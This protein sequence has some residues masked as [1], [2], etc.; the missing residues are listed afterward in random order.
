MKKRKRVYIYIR[1]ST[2]EQAEEGYSL[3][4]QEKNLIDY[5]KA[6]GWEIVYVFIDGGQS[7]ASLERPE[8][9]NMIKGIKQ[10]KADIVL[11]DKLDRLSRSQFDT[12]FLINKV[13]EPNNVSLVSRTEAFDTSTQ[14]GKAMV[15]FMSIFAELERGRIK[16]RTS[17]GR[18]ARA[19]E[20][21]YRGGGKPVIGY[22]YNKI[23]GLL[24]INEYEAMQLREV[25]QL[26]NQRTPVYQI[27][28]R[29]YEKGYRTKHGE[30]QELT[31]RKCVANPLYVGKIKYKGNIYD[32]IHDAIVDQATYK[33]ALQILA[34][35]DMQYEKYKQGRTYHA[36]LGG[37][38][39]CANCGAR[40]HYRTRQGKTT[41][42]YYMCYSR[43]KCDKKMVRDHNCKNTNYRAE[44]LEDAVY[45]EVRKLK[46][47]IGYFENVQSTENESIKIDMIE[48]RIE[49]IKKQIANLNMLFSLDNMDFES[50]QEQIN[51]LN[52][53]R[54]QLMTELELIK[55]GEKRK[56]K[57]E[58]TTLVDIFEKA[59]AEED[60]TRINHI[61][62]ELIDYIEID[63]D[64]MRI[65]WN[66]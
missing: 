19:R 66:F 41:L 17:E 34:E 39:F 27:M 62:T 25:Y 12:L 65:H 10:G 49:Q 15:G 30:W 16:E 21:K 63:Y 53:E 14:M 5:A 13:F 32:G 56:P 64:T 51:P 4:E 9:Q 55:D 57:E 7:G 3:G 60:T 45:T 37:L 54:L 26:F 22:D 1:V 6:M 61:L 23:T 28:L 50:L 2:I 58:V 46:A 44:V 52:V 59:V 8:M 47:E 36:P 31:I 24:E 38:L 43:A 20:G 11:V 40:Y 48:K 18:D 42:K 33:K 29:M 35:R